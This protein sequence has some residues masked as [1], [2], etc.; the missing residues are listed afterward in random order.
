MTW[1][2]KSLTLSQ[3]NL[4]SQDH[5]VKEAT[6]VAETHNINEQAPTQL[7]W[8]REGW[9]GPHLGIHAIAPVSTVSH[10][11]IFI[12]HSSVVL[13]TGTL[14][15]QTRHMQTTCKCT[16]TAVP[17]QPCPSPLQDLQQLM[18]HHLGPVGRRPWPMTRVTE[19]RDVH[20]GN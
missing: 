13:T 4:D 16:P 19:G 17:S 6:V 2:C 18:G 12:M 1:L 9:N 20:I 5:C 3:G 11:F 7:H 14:Q 8:E 10:T 15:P